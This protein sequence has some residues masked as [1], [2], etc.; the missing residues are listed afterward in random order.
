MTPVR[1]RTTELKSA[2]ICRRG[3]LKGETYN[4]FGRTILK[5]NLPNNEKLS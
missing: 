3:K 5:L 2:W 1:Q 4:E